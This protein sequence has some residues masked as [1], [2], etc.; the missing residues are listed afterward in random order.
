ML[1]VHYDFTDTRSCIV[2]I[3][4]Q[5]KKEPQ[6]RLIYNNTLDDRS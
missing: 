6:S 1:S 4:T 2:D 5:M 3:S